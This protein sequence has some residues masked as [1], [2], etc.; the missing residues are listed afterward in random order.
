MVRDLPQF[1]NP[2]DVMVFNDTRV[3]PARLLGF[4]GQA[5]VEVLL[6]RHFLWL[7]LEGEHEH[8]IV[9]G[10]GAVIIKRCP[11][12]PNPAQPLFASRAQDDVTIWQCFAKPAKRLKPGDRI[13]FAED[14]SATVMEKLASG[15]IILRFDE[16]AAALS[17][18][19]ARYGHMP[20][21][22]YIR[23]GDIA[24]DREH[25]QTV[26][27]KHDGSVAAPTAGI[28]FYRIVCCKPSM[29]RVLRARR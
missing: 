10:W 20:L 21:P 1:L 3:I 8:R 19:L 13:D 23:R 14:F 26:Y 16:D 6:H 24:S 4:R 9:T 5:K 17:K 27:A 22:P 15:E 28:A 11:P 29:R 12:H 7:M 18:K 2:G 25:Y